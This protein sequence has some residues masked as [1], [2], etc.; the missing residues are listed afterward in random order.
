MNNGGV[1]NFRLPLTGEAP[2]VDN[3][4]GGGGVYASARVHAVYERVKACL[5][6]VSSG[7]C[8]AQWHAKW[9]F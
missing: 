6:G 1:R 3:K 5:E 7:F 4:P 9:R 8:G 2:I